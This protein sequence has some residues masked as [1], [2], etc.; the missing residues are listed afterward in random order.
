MLQGRCSALLW[1]SELTQDR[2]R[3]Q[4]LIF[5]HFV[6]QVVRE[7][8]LAGVKNFNIQDAAARY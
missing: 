7:D 2:N 5:V 1:I 8:V 6:L 4:K 3:Y